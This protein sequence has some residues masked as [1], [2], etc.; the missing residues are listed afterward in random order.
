MQNGCS[1]LREKYGEAATSESGKNRFKSYRTKLIAAV[2]EL[3]GEEDHKSTRDGGSE[4]DRRERA[5]P[6][7]PLEQTAFDFSLQDLESDLAAL[8]EYYKAL[9]SPSIQTLS[10]D[11]SKIIIRAERTPRCLGSYFELASPH[12]AS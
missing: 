11:D 9:A 2:M 1:A 10:S 7:S 8:V 6:R 5:P 3:H 4:E 12:L